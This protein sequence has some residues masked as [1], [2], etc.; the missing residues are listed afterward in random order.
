VFARDAL[1]IAAV[2]V[3]GLAHIASL[4]FLY[5]DA[6]IT[7]RYGRNLA[8]GVGPV[9]NPGERVEGYSNFLWMLLM[10]AVLAAGRNPET[11]S[12]LAGAACA[13]GSLLVIVF[14]ARRRGIGIG[15]TGLLI[16][17]DRSWAAWGTGGLE[18]SMFSL[19]VSSG[20]VTLMA[21]LS[22]VT[23]T[24][25]ASSTRGAI[26]SGVLFGLA[27]L[28]R[29]DGW[30]ITAG[31]GL[32]IA[33]HAWRRRAPSL[34]VAW[35]VA[36]A[37]MDVPHLLWRHAY[38]HHWLP[39]TFA[40]KT[41]GLAAV[42]HGLA[43]LGDALLGLRLDLLLAI[44]AACLVARVPPRGLTTTDRAVLAF[45]LVPFALY[46]VT[47][48]GDFM[49]A[50]RYVAPLIPLL[51]LGVAGGL[52]GLTSAL[53][54]RIGRAS[55]VLPVAVLVTYGGFNLA[56]SAREQGVWVHGDMVSVGWARNE[57]K[58]WTAIGD[59]LRRVAL[60]TDTL[61]TTAAGAIPYR[62]GLYTVDLHGLNA[63]DLTRY[64]RRATE[65]PGHQLEL[66]ERWLAAQPP[67]I[68][69]GHPL[70]HPT[71]ATLA[72]GLD[73]DPAWRDRVLAHYELVGM[74]VPTSPVRYVGCALRKDAV[75]RILR[76]GGSS[77][78]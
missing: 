28:T 61:A 14:A 69:L 8:A 35:V 71:P 63:P 68:L 27:S 38:Y 50:Y 51:A 45:V 40:A 11:W 77:S 43:Y 17:L 49:P 23:G 13:V 72:L 59:L 47:T 75:E 22:P 64:R 33:A 42:P 62:S 7:F 20:V 32:V 37:I 73:L 1:V 55:A 78:P 36:W 6:Y 60:P 19:L 41:P 70:V 52:D 10:S 16:V 54:T 24:S 5:D 18:T 12:Q 21:A 31:A 15:T 53:S 67:Q 76:A 57:M 29:P 39:N 65:R 56:Q 26:V 30:L 46:L 4:R 66:E 34:A 9:F 3:I 58:D 48:G 2:L 25:R 74:A 44:V